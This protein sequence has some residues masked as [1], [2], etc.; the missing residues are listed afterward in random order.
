M[1]ILITGGAGFIGAE[2]TREFLKRG[3]EV[4]IFD[5]V[6]N[7]ALTGE[8]RVTQVKGD[9]A[10]WPEVL[11]VVGTHKVDT[12]F[13]LAAILSAICEANP[14]SA[15]SIN[16]LG[17]YYVLEAARLFGVR[18]V[19]FTSSMGT[20]T[21]T[22]DTVV[23]ED[24]KQTPM[25]MYGVT[26]VFSELLGLYYHRKFGIDFRGIRFPQLIGPHVKTFSFGQYNP[27]LIEAA[28]KGEAFDVWT[29][30]DTMI[31]L[32]YIKDAVRSLILLSD[33]DENTL[34]TRVYNVG[35]IMPP[36]LAK[37]IADA[38]KKYY[39]DARINFKPDPDAAGVLKSIPRAI[40][41]DVAERE[42]GWRVGYS[43]EDTVKDFIEEFKKGI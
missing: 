21:V 35:Q 13:H 15:V 28:I 33:A 38:V 23:T 31:P 32:L 4:V 16:G 17:T 22:Q 26:K 40:K 7:E 41:G 24:T 34:A 39:P 10:N 19:I 8:E 6:L 27:W 37:D 43:L 18:K 30:E 20:Y 3:E 9:I 25:L 36:P 14:W 2:L 29:A 11:N 42:W 12:V 1:S 5:K